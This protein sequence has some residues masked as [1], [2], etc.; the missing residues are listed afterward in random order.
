MG[1]LYLM[2]CNHI[3]MAQDSKGNP[4]CVICGSTKVAKTIDTIK[5]SK[6]GLEGRQAQCPD[7]GH[8]HQSDWTLPF[9]KYQPEHDFDSCYDGCYGWD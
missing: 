3:A 8:L 4:I 1:E 9:F 7:C 5:D 6:A 2:A